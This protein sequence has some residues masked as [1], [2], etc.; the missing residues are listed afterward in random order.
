MFQHQGLFFF[1]KKILPPSDFLGHVSTLN[2]CIL[3]TFYTYAI[4][5]VFLSLS[6]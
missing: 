2:Y 1:L 5:K 4:V 6:N 3:Y